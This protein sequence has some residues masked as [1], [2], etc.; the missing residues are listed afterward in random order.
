MTGCFQECEVYPCEALSQ[1]YFHTDVSN[2]NRCDAYVEAR[3]QITMHEAPNILIVTLKRFK[4][5]PF[6]IYF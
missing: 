5:C 2:A 3:K 6:A 4:V 1:E